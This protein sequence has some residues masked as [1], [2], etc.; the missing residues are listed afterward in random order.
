MSRAILRPGRQRLFLLHWPYRKHTIVVRRDFR[1]SFLSAAKE[2]ALCRPF[3]RDP[4]NEGACCCCF[5]YEYFPPPANSFPLP[6]SKTF[7][8]LPICAAHS[9]ADSSG[10][11]SKQR[12]PVAAR[13][14]WRSARE[15]NY[16]CRN[17]H[18]HRQM[19][20]VSKIG[21]AE[22]AARTNGP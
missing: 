9:K 6:L 17:C 2:A 14:Y 1:S 4:M 21:R 11:C 16:H 15:C 7:R 12:G 10:S 13:I 20:P 5:H 19:R 3:H 18:R 22:L 8:W